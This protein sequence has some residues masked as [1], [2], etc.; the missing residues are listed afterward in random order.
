MT[1]NELMIYLSQFPDSTQIYLECE[2]G[3]RLIFGG[4][5]GEDK[6]KKPLILLYPVH[7]TAVPNVELT[8][9][10]LAPSSDR[11]ERG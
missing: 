3:P 11:R 7:T 8:G 6:D 2:T 4:T 9:G 10:A 5:T 1:K